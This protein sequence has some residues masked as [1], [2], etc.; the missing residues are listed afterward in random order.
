MEVDV[1]EVDIDKL[2]DVCEERF[3]ARSWQYCQL[4]ALTWWEEGRKALDRLAFDLDIYGESQQP[5]TV[6]LSPSRLDRASLEAWKREER[7]LAEVEDL[8]ERLERWRW[9]EEQEEEQNRL[10][11][12]RERDDQNS[13]DDWHEGWVL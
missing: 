2:M 1:V 6:A 12:L 9:E 10:D 13:E 4:S 7:E 11:D 3:G 8:F 5:K